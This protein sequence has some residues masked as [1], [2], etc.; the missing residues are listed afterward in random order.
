MGCLLFEFLVC[1][2]GEHAQERTTGRNEEYSQNK[3]PTHNATEREDNE[4]ENCATADTVNNLSEESND[5]SEGCDG[6]LH[7][8]SP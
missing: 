8:V 7:V 6:V 2:C 3:H 1:C 5:E 4:D